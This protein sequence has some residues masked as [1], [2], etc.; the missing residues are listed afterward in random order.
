M[1]FK[2]EKVTEYPNVV[3][4]EISAKIGEKEVKET[5]GFSKDKVADGS[6]KNHVKIWLEQQSKK[7]TIPKLEG[8]AFQI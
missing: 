4:I 7:I 8:K 2:V 1:E 5:F 6:W 3:K